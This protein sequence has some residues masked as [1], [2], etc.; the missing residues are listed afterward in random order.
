[1][2]ILHLCSDYSKQKLY[3]ELLSHLSKFDISQKMY[4]P[5]R[6][7]QEIG[8]YDVSNLSNIEVEYSFILKTYHRFL[9]KKKVKTVYSDVIKKIDPEKYELTHAHFLFSDGGVALELYKQYN[10][11]YVVSVRNTDVNY[12]FKYYKHHK[13]YG[14]EILRNAENIIF[15]TPS[16]RDVIGNKYVYSSLKESFE[17][18]CKIIPNGLNEFWFSN[19][20][21]NLQKTISES[22]KLL[23]VGDF[24]PNK[25]V[26]SIIDSAKKLQTEGFS[27]SL[28]LVGGGGKGYERTMK[29]ISNADHTPITYLGRVNDKEK[30]KQI[31]RNH[32]I[33]IMPSF[34]ETFGMVY[35]E[36]M[37]QGVPIIY[38]K[39]QGVDGYF[40]EEKKPGLA[41]NPNDTDDIVEAITKVWNSIDE[42]SANALD[43]SEQFHWDLIADKLFKIY[44]SNIHE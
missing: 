3:S 33:F 5:T 18:K 35:I 39:G 22:I 36:A 23:Y 27:V 1:M 26:E 16:Y 43:V 41:V 34:R 15:V 44:K 4:V 17:K 10:I 20:Q 30:L 38:T 25:N 14:N 8:K 37:S 32:D 9:F 6:S 28:T 42:Y 2:N 12:F 31:Y 13:K 21:T 29:K 24:T 11:P 40:S 19:S 7:K